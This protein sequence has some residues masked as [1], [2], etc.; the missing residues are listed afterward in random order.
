MKFDDIF[1]K[2]QTTDPALIEQAIKLLKE[3]F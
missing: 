2:E 1:E 3:D